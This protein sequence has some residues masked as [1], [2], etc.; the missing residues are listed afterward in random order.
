MPMSIV[1]DNPERASNTLLREFLI[2]F[3]GVFSENDTEEN[4]ILSQFGNGTQICD[5]KTHNF[6]SRSDQDSKIMIL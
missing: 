4:S 1:N 2:F 3:W 6:F 5:L